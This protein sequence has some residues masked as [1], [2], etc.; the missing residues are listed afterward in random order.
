MSKEKEIE[1]LIELELTE[2]HLKEKYLD[3]L[4]TRIS[5][6]RKRMNQILLAL[7]FTV[8]GFP[9]LISSNVKELSIG[10]IK[11][12]EFKIVI[13]SIP[14]LFAFLYYKYISIWMDLTDQKMTYRVMSSKFFNVEIDSFLNQRLRPYSFLDS[15]MDKHLKN[16]KKKVGCLISMLWISGA[17]FALLFPLLFEIYSLKILYEKYQLE[18]FMDWVFFATPILLLFLTGHFIIGSGDND[19]EDKEKAEHNNG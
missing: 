14:T 3:L 17:L 10:P 1:K 4:L 12:D 15:I 5:E 11:L 13:S 19:I 8:I 7:F 9:L 16:Y 6:N 2:N 18:E